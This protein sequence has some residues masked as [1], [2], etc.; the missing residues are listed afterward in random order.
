M[1][2]L[3]DEMAY[4]T[5]CVARGNRRASIVGD[6]SFGSDQEST[7]HALRNACQVGGF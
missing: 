3:L 4:D 6:P 7:K 5:H 2:V 1:P